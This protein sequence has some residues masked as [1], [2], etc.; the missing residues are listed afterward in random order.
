MN[1][2]DTSSYE[3][4]NTELSPPSIQ[5]SRLFIHESGWRID[6]KRGS[7]RV[8]CHMIAPGDDHHHRLLDGELYLF[9]GDER[10]CLNCAGRRGLIVDEPRLLREDRPG[11]VPESN[12]PPYPVPGTEPEPEPDRE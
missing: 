12:Q 7:D 8:F 6:I 1:L 5:T 9:H 3:A 4:R 11:F 2:E 10:V